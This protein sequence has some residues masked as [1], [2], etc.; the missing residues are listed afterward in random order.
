LDYYT[1]KYFYRNI[2][3]DIDMKIFLTEIN[4]YGTTFAGPNIIAK[5]I[6]RAEQAATQNGLV[7]VGQ[8][9]SIYIDDSDGEHMN[10][11]E[12]NEEKIVH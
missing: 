8:L 1:W 12:T 3:L 11:I 4:A 7:V 2:H 10:M 5:T 9:D 6:E